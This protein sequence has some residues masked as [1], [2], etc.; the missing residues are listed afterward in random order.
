MGNS[1]A[2]MCFHNM[3]Y[4]PPHTHT[5]THT[6]EEMRLGGLEHILPENED[7]CGLKPGTPKT[8]VGQRQED[9]WGLLTDSP[10]LG[11]VSDAFKGIRESDRSG[12]LL[13][14]Y[15]DLYMFTRGHAQP[16]SERLKPYTNKKLNN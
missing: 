3:V 10:T 1:T 15:Y 9:H 11:S 6:P 13:T 7:L 8:V 14:F 16:H 2:H 4:T 12:Y 5:L